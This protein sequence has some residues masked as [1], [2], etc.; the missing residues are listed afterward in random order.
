MQAVWVIKAQFARPELFWQTLEF[1]QVTRS[2]T[3]FG[4]HPVGKQDLRSAD[5]IG[6]PDE[7][8]DIDH[9]AQTD[10]GV[11]CLKQ[12]SP[13]KGDDL[14]AGCVQWIK[15]LFQLL[16]PPDPVC[17]NLP[18]DALAGLLKL[19]INVDQTLLRQEVQGGRKTIHDRVA[20]DPIPA[21]GVSQVG[22]ALLKAVKEGGERVENSKVDENIDGRRE[23][24]DG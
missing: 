14:D 24:G 7:D 18:V 15:Q 11:D 22:S 17:R 3:P 16:F 8:I 6:T 1:E 9:I 2:V 4:L 12:G 20:Q 19:I 5:V 21:W 13:F 10:V 23:T